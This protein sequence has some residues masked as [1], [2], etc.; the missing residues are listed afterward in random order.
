MAVRKDKYLFANFSEF[1]YGYAVTRESE[2]VLE[3][4]YRSCGVPTLPSL[5]AE[6]D[7]GYDARA[8]YVGYALFFQ[9]KRSVYVSRRHPKSPTWPAFGSR[10]YRIA[11][12][13]DE[14]QHQLLRELEIDLRAAS[15]RAEVFYVAPS[16][17]ENSVLNRAYLAGEVL[18]RSFLFS[19]CDLPLSDGIHHFASLGAGE[20]TWILS[21]PHIPDRQ[22]SWPVMRNKIGQS[23]DVGGAE[24]SSMITLADL[25]DLISIVAR[26]AGLDTKLNAEVPVVERVKRAALVLGC[27]MS[28]ILVGPSETEIRG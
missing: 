18:D 1:T 26:R 19:P 6:N 11:I 4:I 23:A 12:N 20:S 17:H 9:F 5:R 7:L 28:L 15:D 3:G 13:T 10:H 27:S 22:L 21:K 25:E 8:V 24:A 16:F 2:N 14:R